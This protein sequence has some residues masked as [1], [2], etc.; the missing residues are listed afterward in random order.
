MATELIWL[1]EQLQQIDSEI[2]IAT[3]IN[4]N[5][6]KQS[7]LIYNMWRIQLKKRIEEIR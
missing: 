5:N 4:T 7:V 1:K 2:N 6:A 3:K